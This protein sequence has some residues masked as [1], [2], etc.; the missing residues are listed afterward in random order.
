MENNDRN[1]KILIMYRQKKERK[2]KRFEK[3]C[4]LDTETPTSETREPL[5]KKE[6]KNPNP[7]RS[8]HII[9]ILM[10]FKRVILSLIYDLNV[11]CLFACKCLS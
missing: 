1:Y 3:K 8:E 7:E 6:D 9:K 5:P 4:K 11:F 10:Y 2:N